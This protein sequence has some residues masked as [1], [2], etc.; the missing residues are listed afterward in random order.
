MSLT[1][2]ADRQERNL[3]INGGF[4][5]WQ[6]AG[7]TAAV[8]TTTSLTYAGPD[9]WKVMHT[10]T[11][12]GTPNVIRDTTIPNNSFPYSLK[13]TFQRNASAATLTYEQRVESFLSAEVST[14]GSASLS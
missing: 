3:L 1:P 14:L 13:H 6:R 4:A 9:R 2:R 11:F 5:T 7:A 8:N 10:G 12:T